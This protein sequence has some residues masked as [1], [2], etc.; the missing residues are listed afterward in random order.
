[1]YFR[2]GMKTHSNNIPLD[3][4]H[5]YKINTIFPPTVFAVHTNIFT[6]TH[7]HPHSNIIFYYGVPLIDII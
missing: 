5:G 7:T 6:Q 4:Q 3:K 2:Y 1:M